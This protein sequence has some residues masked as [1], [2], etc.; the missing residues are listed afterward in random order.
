VGLDRWLG[1]GRAAT[2]P[3]PRPDKERLP[4]LRSTDVRQLQPPPAFGSEFLWKPTGPSFC[5][6]TAAGCE[7]AAA[8]ERSAL[9]NLQ[10]VSPFS[11]H[12]GFL[13]KGLQK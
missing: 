11:A 9:R 3:A 4:S 1:A 5:L 8:G 10:K 6:V 13:P 7:I 2:L 12:E